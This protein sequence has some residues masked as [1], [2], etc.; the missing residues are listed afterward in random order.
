[1]GRS[2]RKRKKQGFMALYA[3][4]YKAVVTNNGRSAVTDRVSIT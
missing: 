1:M 4:D 3:K 2:I